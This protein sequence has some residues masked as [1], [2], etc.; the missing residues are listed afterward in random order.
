MLN[1][2]I[3]YVRFINYGLI[4]NLRKI[5]RIFYKQDFHFSNQ[6]IIFDKIHRLRSILAQLH[7]S[8]LD[9]LYYLI[10]KIINITG[11]QEFYIRFSKVWSNT[12]LKS[13]YYMHMDQIYIMGRLL[14][15]SNFYCK[16]HKNHLVMLL[17]WLDPNEMIE[18]HTKMYLLQ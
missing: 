14:L 12:N 13:I 9:T 10:L 1:I 16:N 7:L 11:Q 18:Q 8:Y 2:N 4:N 17:Y 15:R 5:L 3:F 6:I